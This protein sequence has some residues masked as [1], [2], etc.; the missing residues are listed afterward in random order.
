[1][2]ARTIGELKRALAG[3][4][5]KIL[6]SHP[7]PAPPPT[8]IEGKATIPR[9]QW[10]HHPGTF[11]REH[12]TSW[13]WPAYLDTHSQPWLAELRRIYASGLS[14][15]ASIS[16]EGG[17]LLHALVRNIRPKVVAETGTWLGVSTIWMA[18][19]LADA[20]DGGLVHTFDLFAPIRKDQWRDEELT[21]DRRG[22]VE[23]SFAR[24]GLADRIVVH[25]GYSSVQLRAAH[26][27]LREAGGV[28]LALL[29]ADHEVAGASHDFWAL[30]P[31]L[32]VGGYVIF[33]DVFPEYCGHEGPRHI[34]DRINQIGVGVYERCDLCLSPVNYG[35]GVAR[36]IG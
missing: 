21:A 32:A 13:T 11:G 18:A 34:L 9:P 12:P 35:L 24:A 22:V 3:R 7:P 23:A 14:F 25:Q 10:A 5:W 30:E 26:E 20:G 4:A 15:P 33:H 2:K 19:A 1:M 16:P 6:T 36:R 28:Q 29:D 17:L 8:V 31:V 27:A